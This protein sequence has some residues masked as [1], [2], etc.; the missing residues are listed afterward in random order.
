MEDMDTTDH[1]WW[2]AGVMQYQFSGPDVYK[3]PI[4]LHEIAALTAP[5]ALVETG[6]TNSYWLANESNY[7]SARAV[8]Q[9]YNTFGIG[10]HRCAGVHLARLEV[11]VTLQEWLK[12]IPEFRVAQGTRPHYRTGMVALAENVHLAW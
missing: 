6:N 11:I 2:A 1:H 12:R 5:R 10:T 8:Q 4:D 9:V 3:L 7:V